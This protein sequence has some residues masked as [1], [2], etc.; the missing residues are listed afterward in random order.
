MP[1]HK[2]KTMAKA[3]KP[4]GGAAKDKYFRELFAATEGL[5]LALAKHLTD[6]V[7]REIA[8]VRVRLPMPL[9]AAVKPAK[10]K[11]VTQ[12]ATAP[13]A[14][15][16]PEAAPFDPFAISAMV[17]LKR[18]GK[19]ELAKQLA[20]ITDPAHLK[21]LADKQHLG[22]PASAATADELRAAIVAAAEARINDRRAAAS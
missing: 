7:G 15:P 21:L 8:Q 9:R 5:D 1:D 10:E 17:V 16:L 6:V 13:P 11:R 12:P 4:L 19:A 2:T 22:V 3:T 20:T 14:P 18:K